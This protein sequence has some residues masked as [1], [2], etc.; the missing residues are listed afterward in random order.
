MSRGRSVVSLL[1]HGTVARENLRNLKQHFGKD[2]DT[3]AGKTGTSDAA[4]TA[5]RE[6]AQLQDTRVWSCTVVTYVVPRIKNYTQYPVTVLSYNDRFQGNQTSASL[7]YPLSVFNKN[8]TV[9]LK[10]S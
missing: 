4:A 9:T 2:C 5:S 7:G 3:L 1:G 10:R 6:R 8:S